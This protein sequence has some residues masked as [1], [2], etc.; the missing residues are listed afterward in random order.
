MQAAVRR[1]ETKTKK[2]VRVAILDT[3]VD[4]THKDIH[5]AIMSNTIYGGKGFPNSLSPFEDY[6]GHGTHVASCFLKTAPSALLYIVR[7]NDRRQTRSSREDY[8]NMADVCRISAFT[9]GRQLRGRVLSRKW[10]SFP[11]PGG[12]KIVSV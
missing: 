6:H 8:Q 2:K 10:T 4:G 7:V 12:W 9:D 1:G 11:C 5:E 3:G